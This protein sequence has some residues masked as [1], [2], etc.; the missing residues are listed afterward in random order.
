M[1]SL[2]LT[3]SIYNRVGGFTLQEEGYPRPGSARSNPDF[4]TPEN[5]VICFRPVQLSHKESN[6]LPVAFPI[7][8]IHRSG[9][10]TGEECKWEKD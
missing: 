3:G 5:R 7:I 9:R 10:E 1:S 6:D 4:F 8:N 2:P